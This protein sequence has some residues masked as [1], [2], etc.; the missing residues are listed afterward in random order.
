MS[1]P[2]R[3]PAAVLARSSGSRVLVSGESSEK[4]SVFAL[5]DGSFRQNLYGAPVRVRDGSGGWAPV[6]TTLVSRAGR[7][8]AAAAV[9]G[10]SFSPGGDSDAVG[11]RVPGGMLGLGWSSSLPRPVLRGSTARYRG[12]VPGGDLLLN[13]TRDGFEFSAVL[14]RRPPGAM[15]IK[16]PL[17]LPAGWS[18]RA[19]SPS[20]GWEVLDGSGAARGELGQTVMTGAKVGPQSGVPVAQQVV[21]SQVVGDGS[22]GFTLVLSPAAQFLSDP[23]TVYPVTIDPSLRLT[24]TFDTY[25]QS[26]YPT[27]T[28]GCCVNELHVG[29]YDDQSPSSVDRTFIR[30]D[31]SSLAG[32]A[33]TGASLYL[34]EVHQWICVPQQIYVESTGGVNAAT[35]WANM[36]SG[37]R[38]YAAAA[39]NAGD[40][41]GGQRYVG[42][43]ITSLAK[44]WASGAASNTMLLAAVNEADHNDY[45]RFSAAE[46]PSTQVPYVQVNAASAPSAPQN[47][48]ASAASGQ[49]TL[50]WGAPA[51]NGGAAVSS[52]T[53]KLFDKTTGGYAVTRTGVAGGPLTLT[54]LSDGHTYNGQVSAI[55]AAGSSPAGT[56]NDVTPVGYPGPVRSLTALGHTASISASWTAPASDGGSPVGYYLAELLQ[57]S[58]VSGSQQVTGTSVSLPATNGATYTVRVTAHNGCGCSAA[59]LP[60]G[61][62]TQV[63]SGPVTAAGYP[64]AAQGVAA[65]PQD[66]QVAL[67]WTAPATSNGSAVDGYQ[68]LLDPPGA[69][70]DGSLGTT[71]LPG[72]AGSATV[73]AGATLTDGTHYVAW[74][75]AHNGSADGYTTSDGRSYPAGYGPPGSSLEFVPAAVPSAPG[76]PQATPDSTGNAGQSSVTVSWNPSAA[77]GSPV[78]SYTVQALDSQNGNSP[79]GP[80]VTVP[81]SQSS[82]DVPG[83]TQNHRYTFSITADNGH[84]STPTVLYAGGTGPAALTGPVTTGT[85]PT[86]TK[87]V[88][89][90]QLVSTAGGN[91]SAVDAG[92]GVTYTISISNPLSRELP[93][94]A[95][96]DRLPAGLSAGQLPPAGSTNSIPV[97]VDGVAFTGAPQLLRDATG[98]LSLDLSALSFAGTSGPGVLPAGGTVNVHFAAV[99]LPQAAAGCELIDNTAAVSNPYG[100]VSTPAGRPSDAG[101]G[102]LTACGALLGKEAWWSY[103]SLPVAVGSTAQLNA[104]DGNLVLTQ[105]DAVPVQAHGHLS[106]Q[107]RRAYNSQDTTVATLPGSF[108]K[109]WL[110]NVGQADDLADVGVM[111]SGLSVPSVQ[112]LA[113]AAAQPLPVTLIDRDGTRHAFTPNALSAVLTVGALPAGLGALSPTALSAAAGNAICID[114]TYTA[115][116]GVHLGL[117]RYVQLPGGTACTAG[118]IAAGGQLLGFAAERPDR[119]RTEYDAT[120]RLLAMTDQAGV[121]LGYAYNALTAPAQGAG[122]LGVVY[123]ASQHTA[124]GGACRPTFSGGIATVTGCRTLTISYDSDTQTTLT[125]PSGQRTVYTFHRAALAGGPAGVRLLDRVDNPAGHGSIGY[126]YQGDGAVDCGA[127]PGQLCTISD[128]R[129]HV[130]SF[131]YDQASKPSPLALARVSGVTDRRGYHRAYSYLRGDGSFGDALRVDLPG[132]GVNSTGA[133]TDLSAPDR[134]IIYAHIDGDGRVGDVFAGAPGIS[135]DPAS[136]ASN[137]AR[138]TMFGWDGPTATDS[139]GR[140]CRLDGAQRRE[141]D[142]CE[143]RRV[144]SNNAA[145]PGGTSSGVPTPDADTS[146]RYDDAGMLLASAVSAARADGRS[147]AATTLSSTDGYDRQYATA[148][149]TAAGTEQPTGQGQLAST[150][151]RPA[152]GG[153]GLPDPATVLYTL[154]DHAAHLGGCGNAAGTAGACGQEPY[155]ADL[156]SM[157]V[158]DNPAAAPN[159]SPAQTCPGT[160]QTAAGYTPTGN[161]GLLCQTSSPY[162]LDRRAPSGAPAQAVTVNT[163]GA[164][165]E[166]TA[167]STPNGASYRYAY[168]PDGQTDSTGTI[169]AGGWLLGTVDPLAS[170]PTPGDPGSATSRFV[171]FGYDPYGHIVATWDRNAT[172]AAGAPLSSYA[173]APPAGAPAARSLYNTGA[174][175]SNT[176]WRW[177][178]SGTDPVGNTATSTVDNSGDVLT[179]TDARGAVTTATYD[180]AALRTSSLRPAENGGTPAPSREGYDAFTDRTTTTSPNASAA[181]GSSTSAV[182]AAM[183]YDS[184]GRLSATHTVRGPAA[185][186]CPV[187]AGGPYPAGQSVCTSTVGYDS[188][189]HPVAS[190]DTG[191]ALTTTVFDAAGRT[192]TITTPPDDGRAITLPS[193]GSYNGLISRTVYDADSKPTTACSARQQT[194]GADLCTDAASGYLTHIHY[195]VAGRALAVDTYRSAGAPALTVTATFDADGNQ[196]TTTDRNGHT[197]RFG[198]D[199]LDRRT[200]SAVPR[201]ATTSLTTSTVYDPVGDTVATVAPGAAGD[202]IGAGGTGTDVRITGRSFDADHRGLDSVT[203]LQVPASNPAGLTYND[204]ALTGALAGATAT[205]TANTRSRT[206]YD[207]AG[208]PVAQYDPRA[209]TAAVPAGDQT[210][211][212]QGGFTSLFMTRTDYDSDNRPTAR[213]TPRADDGT[214]DP[215]A[216]ALSGNQAAQCA[217]TGPATPGLPSYPTDHPRICVSSVGYDPNGNITTA[218]LPTA[219]ASTPGRTLSA[220]YTA[221]NLTSRT[222]APDPA[223]SGSGTD[224]AGCPAGQVPTGRAGFDAQG[225]TLTGTDPLGLLTTNVYYPDGHLAE[226]DSPAGSAGPQHVTRYG[227]DANSQ[228]VSQTVP[229]STYDSAGLSTGSETD[230]ATRSWSAD[231]LL[232]TQTSPGASTSDTNTTAYSYDNN[233]NP[234]RVTSPSAFYNAHRPTGAVPDANNTASTDTINT[235]TYDN[236]LAA[237]AVPVGADGITFRRTTSTFDPAGRVSAQGTDLTGPNPPTSPGDDST[238]PVLQPGAPI[239]FGYAPNDRQ[240]SK[241]GRADSGAEQIRIGFD[242]AGNP[243]GTTD[244]HGTGPGASTTTVQAEFYADS[245]PR[246]VTQTHPGQGP[247]TTGYSYDGAGQLTARA[248]P[249]QPTATWTVNDAGLPASMSGP[250]DYNWTY[251]S[252][253]HRLS[254]TNPNGTSQQ[255]NWNDRGT[256]PVADGT[257]AAATLTG[258]AGTLASD[259]YRYDERYQ[260]I[261]QSYFGAAAAGGTPVPASAP[262]RFGYTYDPAG[263]L[264]SFTHALTA[265]APII[266]PI[267]YDHDSN[268][269]TY[270]PRTFTYTA[271]DAL[272]TD[273]GNA[274]LGAP[275]RNYRYDAEGRTG[276]D[277]CQAYTYDGLDRA[278][279]IAAAPGAPPTCTGGAPPPTGSI[280]YGYDGTDRQTSRTDST[281]PAG[282]TSTD[283]TYDGLGTGLLTEATTGGSAPATNH[284][285][286]A[287]SGG[288]LAVARDGGAPAQLTD[289]GHS[290]IATV[291]DSAGTVSCTVRYDPYGTPASNTGQTAPAGT[292]NTG[293]TT[294]DLFYRGERRDPASGNYQ[295]GAKTYDPNRA[296]YLTPDTPA[297][298]GSPQSPAAGT[299]PLTRNTYSYVNGDPINGTDP[300]GHK[301]D[302]SS[303]GEN[304]P[305]PGYCNETCAKDIFAQYPKLGSFWH[306]TVEAG[307]QAASATGNFIAGDIQHPSR[308]LTQAG[309]L[310]AGIITST[311]DDF[312]HLDISTSFLTSPPSSSPRYARCE[313]CAAPRK[314]P[315]FSRSSEPPKKSPRPP[316]RPAPWKPPAQKQP[317]PA[318]KAPGKAQKEPGPAPRPDPTGPRPRPPPPGKSPTAHSRSAPQKTAGQSSTSEARLRRVRDSKVTQA[319][320]RTGSSE[321]QRRK[322]RTSRPKSSAAA[323]TGCS[324]S[325]PPTTLATGSSTSRRSIRQATSS[326]SSRT[327]SARTD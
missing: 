3:G 214:P 31:T 258:P 62:G 21:P 257:L 242:A 152:P 130:T 77:N 182:S 219:T 107:V 98:V 188:L 220:A 281:N 266:S 39:Y 271:D 81:G 118:N 206:V 38:N 261:D 277:G 301:F 176:P 53:V 5:P 194:D 319:P 233:G 186:G 203:G 325:R 78:D 153:N 248:V 57:G 314:P 88:S 255:W 165:G 80:P 192:L 207:R 115:P 111:T 322:A 23:A 283:F 40:T 164:D 47:V 45:H 19:L 54:G 125:D 276:A 149:G 135:F 230:T 288:P 133:G 304:G 90:P 42:A 106:L 296:G 289:D 124:G 235:Y 155:T 195:D 85:T 151:T 177:Q 172:S 198:Y 94:G 199:P 213:Y 293:S 302:P 84:N 65:S 228:P 22:G 159:S 102:Q 238:A 160:P 132:G 101:G 321:M 280:T 60:A 290:S 273:S 29:F 208:N 216:A 137:A 224:P 83:L 179:A 324:S 10:L 265:G 316:K 317:P 74:V 234:T 63:S 221:D 13:A 241:N 212:D 36:P 191:G 109:G 37:V 275:A 52:Y 143:L 312:V 6:D 72:A 119:L 25:T 41:C 34:F 244:T 183:D 169:N 202:N 27:S 66:R 104:A 163:Y 231:G 236:L 110:L 205:G 218:T 298:A 211:G 87:T 217:G 247:A 144:G 320:L 150:V 300:T 156:T 294:Q 313:S 309:G 17:R 318:Q 105:T 89:G 8:A 185:A 274:A 128:E 287:A 16:V 11:V 59:G 174:A 190:T 225:R 95:L 178:L 134:Q 68:V 173:T 167:M 1:A 140:Y 292:C 122:Q 305:R 268:R 209:F 146:F 117:W 46:A 306:Q 145:G 323:A 147:S 171:A 168:Y 327:R 138:R 282:T 246:T 142:L 251:D 267:S 310:L 99:A 30:F 189:D 229:R 2:D 114:Q 245:Q 141:N 259:S 226:T 50:N 56:S 157:L 264:A 12:A 326:V 181:G 139:I 210:P 297:A 295:L 270:G 61:Y 116:A 4:A 180:P 97:G 272:A 32:K 223:G 307:K 103:D 20:G 260:Q 26:A 170:Y 166:K 243:T 82:A 227:Y 121:T 76:S 240:V 14:D 9:G 250:A 262:I 158:D 70:P 315:K 43:D 44:D 92:Q 58:S 7:L 308:I 284:Y 184:V 100:S 196:L 222:C 24:D 148:S 256:Q 286:L 64:S 69:A 252:S 48:T 237:A 253:G 129:G 120:G 299:D 71:Y 131:G 285:L 311:V 75:S 187:P 91:H 67:S 136:G 278:A 126:T 113:Q 35:D 232:T 123:E 162:G 127:G 96:S 49:V 73:P 33:V 303:D 197:T 86:V 28:Y 263:R 154:A 239:T 215:N 254:Q 79:Y 200:S 51:S 161:T 279:S 55:N 249:G 15:Q 269:L 108:G 112:S 291:T 93:V 201:D 193:A 175:P 18:V 204:P